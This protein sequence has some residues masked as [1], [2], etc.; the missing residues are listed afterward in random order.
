MLV[1][2]SFEELIALFDNPFPRLEERR[3]LTL[4]R[5]DTNVLMAIPPIDNP[6]ATAL[7]SAKLPPLTRLDL[8]LARLRL[9]GPDRLDGYDLV[10]LESLIAEV[11]N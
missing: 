4:L 10:R 2:P 1:K 8:F 11:R 9:K 5:R 6:L 3:N 7:F